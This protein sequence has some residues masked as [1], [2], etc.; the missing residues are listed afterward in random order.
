[1]RGAWGTDRNG[2]AED[3]SYISYAVGETERNLWQQGNRFEREDAIRAAAVSDD[4]LFRIEVGQ[5]LLT[6]RRGHVGGDRTRGNDVDGDAAR[7][8]LTRG[9]VER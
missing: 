4:L 1:M 7:S 5:P 8:E 6:Q 2:N 3:I 9:P